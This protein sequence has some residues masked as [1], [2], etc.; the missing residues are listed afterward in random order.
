MPRPLDRT[1][2]EQ[3]LAD[4]ERHVFEGLE[5]ICHQKEIIA[6]LVRDQHGPAVIQQARS[7]LKTLMQSQSLYVEER[8]RLR[9]ELLKGGAL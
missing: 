6:Q 5:R 1:A 3:Q 9:A 2:T 7:V 8:D 4:A